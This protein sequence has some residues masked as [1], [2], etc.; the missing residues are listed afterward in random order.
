VLRPASF[1]SSLFFAIAVATAGAQSVS[2]YKTT[3][4]L[5]DTLSPQ[6][7]HRFTTQADSTPARPLITIDDGQ[8][9]QTIDGFGASLTAAAW[10]F[11]NKLTLA[12]TDAAFRA[13]FSRNDG[14]AL[15]FLRQPIGP[16][17][18]AV[19]FYSYD[20]LCPQTAKACT[21]PAES[22]DP[23]LAG[24]SLMRD[25]QYILPLLSKA[26]T[27]NRTIRVMLTPWSAPG[28]MKTSGSMLG[29]SAD[30]K[31]PS[32][33]RPDF[34]PAF[35]S[36]LVKAIRRRVYR[37]TRRV[38][39]MSRSIRRPHTQGA[40]D[41]SARL[42]AALHYLK[43]QHDLSDEDVVAAWVD[44]PYWQHF[45]FMTHFQHQCR[46]IPQFDALAQAVGRS[47][48]RAGV[49]RDDRSS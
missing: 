45:S 28:W 5:H 38:C 12:Q 46:L 23:I 1:A 43:Y 25:R 20:D 21:P 32:S 30:G 41:I 33:L 7:T 16:S 4:D 40:P 9:F 2:V 44:N 49:A 10:L 8:R 35:A 13:L 15:S 17:D 3:P 26:L 31:Q 42:M 11:A 48:C 34:Y 36:Y 19:T 24:F 47:R 6:Q 27:L 39:R 37:S 22:A 29:A 14:I 18:L